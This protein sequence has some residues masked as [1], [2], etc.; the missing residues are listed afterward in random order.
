M[1]PIL[2]YAFKWLLGRL[3]LSG[4]AG[5]LIAAAIVAALFAGWS[6]YMVHVGYRWADNKAEVLA[7]QKEKAQLLATIAEHERQLKIANQIIAADVETAAET[8]A[9]ITKLEGMINATPSNP[10]TC[11]DRDAVGRVRNVR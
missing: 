4:F 8:S 7:L 3:G 2:A 6:G 5:G 1:T 10:G 9:H 11:L